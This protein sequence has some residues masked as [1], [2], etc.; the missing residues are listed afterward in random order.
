MSKKVWNGKIEKDEF[1]QL[2]ESSAKIMG[3]EKEEVKKE[4]EGN[5]KIGD[6]VYNSFGWKV[7]TAIF[8]GEDPDS[9]YHYLLSIGRSLISAPKS[10]VFKDKESAKK[11]SEKGESRIRKEA[12]LSKA[13]DDDRIKGLPSGNEH[14]YDTIDKNFKIAFEEYIK[15]FVNDGMINELAYSVAEMA[16]ANFQKMSKTPDKDFGIFRQEIADFIN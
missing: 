5:F 15:G 10:D 7:R 3:L 12:D 14:K 4:A 16:L 13:G 6:T 11:A 2:Q 9:E 8:K 1:V